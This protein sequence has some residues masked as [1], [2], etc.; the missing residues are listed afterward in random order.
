MLMML[1]NALGTSLKRSDKEFLD[2][3]YVFYMWETFVLHM[4]QLEECME[5]YIRDYVFSNNSITS[6]FVNIIRPNF[7]KLDTYHVLDETCHLNMFLDFKVGVGLFWFSHFF[8]F[9][10][11]FFSF[12]KFSKTSFLTYALVIFV[13]T[14]NMRMKRKKEYPK[15]WDCIFDSKQGE[16]DIYLL[17]HLVYQKN[18]SKTQTKIGI[19]WNCCILYNQCV[20]IASYSLTIAFL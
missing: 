2:P 18:Q 8:F 10:F 12:W 9:S 14:V 15:P 1:E 5:Y 11:L 6:L 13:K 4:H 16:H 20:H 3:I 19:N 17:L 7:I